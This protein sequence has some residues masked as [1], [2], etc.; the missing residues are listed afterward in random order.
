MKTRKICSLFL[1]LI[2]TIVA[3]SQP[4]VNYDESKVPEFELPELL[5]ANNGAKIKSREK[6]E[7]IRRPEIVN[8]LNEEMY[9]FYP[10]DA[11]LEVTFE[12]TS[13]VRNALGGK[14]IRKETTIHISNGEKTFDVPVLIYL[15]GNETKKPVPVFMGLNFAGNHT[16]Q[17]DPGITPLKTPCYEPRERGASAKQWPVKEIIN[18][19]YGIMTACYY[20]F[21]PDKAE[22][23]KEGFRSLIYTNGRTPK[24]NE[25]G[26]ISAWT[27]G[28]SRMLDYTQTDPDI[29]ENKVIVFGHSRLGKVAVYAGASDQ[30]FAIV[31]SNDSGCGGAA[32]SKRAFGETIKIANKNFPHW[33]CENFKKYNDNEENL[34]FDQHEVLALIAPRPLYVASA[35]EDSWADPRGE[36]LSACYASPAYELY[37]KKG[38]SP[39]FYP[40][41]DKPVMNQI[42][43]HKRTGKHDITLFDWNNYMDFSDK[44]LSKK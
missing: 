18:R 44:H 17:P 13:T 3:Y 37:E 22:G 1:G 38:L 9:G 41:A 32:L 33:F 30:R 6:W 15:P 19:G 31:I 20:S 12:L 28:M 5:V 8:L 21:E 26:A 24:N 35:S 36:Y 29:D 27:W 2:A 43:Y 10:D 39:R 42:A 16:I 14:A 25:W 40:E 7:K 4:V 23:Y 34:S 11:R